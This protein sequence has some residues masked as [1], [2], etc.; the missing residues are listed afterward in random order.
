MVVW[1]LT[2]ILFILFFATFVRS[3]FGFGEA[4]IAVPLL[5]FIIPIGVATPVVV[6]LSITVASIIIA[7][8]WRQVNF[9]SAGWLFLSTIVGLPLGLWL[10][11]AVGEGIVKVILAT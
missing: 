7:Q 11:T 5:A 4:L 6:L 3:A 2:L 10:L 1:E 9:R 8:D